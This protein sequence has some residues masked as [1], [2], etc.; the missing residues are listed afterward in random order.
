MTAQPADSS[1]PV[2]SSPEIAQE[3]LK[4]MRGKRGFVGDGLHWLGVR[5]GIAY[6]GSFFYPS[7]D[8][9]I[10]ETVIFPH[11]QLSQE[12][13]KI[14]FVGTAWYTQGYSRMFA[15]KTYTSI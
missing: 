8:R 9:S 4:G 1:P 5:L 14:V 7:E 3:R 10:L 6:G 13:Q 15:R 12:H 11:Y 2:P